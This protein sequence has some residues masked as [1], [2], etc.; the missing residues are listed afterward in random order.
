MI[1]EN[2][3]DFI[4]ISRD[5]KMFL[6]EEGIYRLYINEFNREEQHRWRITQSY[7]GLKYKT[8]AEFLSADDLGYKNNKLNRKG[9]DIFIDAAFLWEN[10]IDGDNF[11]SDMQERWIDFIEK[12]YLYKKNISDEEVEKLEYHWF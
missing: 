11:W 10:T 12:K 2:T 3:L 7:T 1:E 5:F 6:K 9:Y 4:Q 8:V